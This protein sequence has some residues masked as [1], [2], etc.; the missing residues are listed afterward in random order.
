MMCQ[1]PTHI[2]IP[3]LLHIAMQMWM[4]RKCLTSV[5]GHL[6]PEEDPYWPNFIR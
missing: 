6:I 2:G 5:I 4:L 3:L 1:A